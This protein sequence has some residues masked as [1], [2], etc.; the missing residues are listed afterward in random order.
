VIGLPSPREVA[1]PLVLALMALAVLGAAYPLAVWAIGRAVAPWQSEGSPLIV[2]GAPIGSA[3]VASPP[4]SS[5]LFSPLPPSSASSGEDPYVPLDYALAQVPRI[6]NATGIPQGQLRALVYRVAS[7]DS[8][9]DLVIFGPG[10]PV[11][12]VMQL[13]YELMRLYPQAH[14]R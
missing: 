8:L 9:K 6:S 7:E 2:N 13:N 12:N 4:N 11:V 10:R 5:A 14:G 3:L 1:A